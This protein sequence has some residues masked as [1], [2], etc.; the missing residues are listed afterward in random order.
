MMNLLESVRKSVHHHGKWVA[1]IG[2]RENQA[3]HPPV[4]PPGDTHLIDL[5]AL[6]IRPSP[7]R[8]LEDESYGSNSLKVL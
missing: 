2:Y 4:E 5:S 7:D 1:E 6:K 8:A 3:G